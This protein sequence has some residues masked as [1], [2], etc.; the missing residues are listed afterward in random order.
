M[1]PHHP[2]ILTA[3]SCESELA[4]SP[5][6]ERGT[7]IHGRLFDKK[8]IKL[9]THHLCATF[10]VPRAHFAF[11]KL[12]MTKLVSNFKMRAKCWQITMPHLVYL[13]HK[14]GCVPPSQSCHKG[15]GCFRVHM[16]T[17]EVS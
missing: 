15:A 8:N 10:P 5:H 17:F 7:Y 2:S 16:C 1:S 9:G 11:I 4:V 12:I 3:D 14:M 6:P 13:R